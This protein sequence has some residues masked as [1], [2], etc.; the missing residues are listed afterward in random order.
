MSLSSY[1][2]HKVVQAG[3]IEGIVNYTDPDTLRTERKLIVTNSEG[4]TDEI[5]I[6]VDYVEKH[7]PRAGGYYVLY[8]D[9]Y[10]S[11]SPA[12][13]FLEGYVDLSKAVSCGMAGYPGG[14]PPLTS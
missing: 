1:K 14:H 9:G 12:D 6:S 11:F 10:E 5:K 8:A 4:E 7:K 3:E 2:C 13:P